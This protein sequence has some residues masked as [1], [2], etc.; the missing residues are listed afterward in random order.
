MVTALIGTETIA[1]ERRDHARKPNTHHRGN[2]HWACSSQGGRSR[3]CA[4]ILLRC[5]WVRGDATPE[6]GRGVHFGRRLS[7]PHRFEH[8]GKQRR[9]P[10]PA[11]THGTVSS[12]NSLSEPP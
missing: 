2:A 11:A 6:L 4:G 7:P 9:P 3:S 10:P 1:A 5:A 8:L 12:R